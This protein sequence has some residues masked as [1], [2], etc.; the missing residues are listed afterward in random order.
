L[1]QRVN[2]L[3]G[4]CAENVTG[5]VSDLSTLVF[6]EFSGKLRAAVIAIARNVS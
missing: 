6:H 4:R 5:K 3:I 1:P 2:D